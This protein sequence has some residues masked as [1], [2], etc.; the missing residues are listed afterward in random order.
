[1]RSLVQGRTGLCKRIVGRG[2]VRIY[3]RSRDGAMLGSVDTLSPLFRVIGANNPHY[4][5]NLMSPKFA[6]L[7]GI[8]NLT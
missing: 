7:N 4:C 5:I 8:G 3:E 6:R 1:M 2:C